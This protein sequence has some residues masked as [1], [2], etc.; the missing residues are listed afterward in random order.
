MM[1]MQYLYFTAINKDD[2]QFQ[3]L[4]TQLDMALKNKSLSPDAVFS[5]SLAATLYAHNPR[6]TNIN[7]KDLKDINYDRILAMLSSMWLLCLLLVRRLRT[8]TR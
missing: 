7:V 3:N 5:D 6:F 1:Q 4:M 8:S 2:K